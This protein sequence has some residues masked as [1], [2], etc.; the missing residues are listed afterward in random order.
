MFAQI[1][2]HATNDRTIAVRVTVH[3]I[4]GTTFTDILPAAQTPRPGLRARGETRAAAGGEA[5]A[6]R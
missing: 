6:G 4:D 2:D 5:S 3:E 1:I